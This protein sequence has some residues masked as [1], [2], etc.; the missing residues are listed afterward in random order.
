M[1]SV[2]SISTTGC[3][4][5]AWLFC[6]NYHLLTH[7]LILLIYYVY[8]SLFSVPFHS[9]TPPHLEYQLIRAYISCFV[10]WCSQHLRTMF[11]GT[12]GTNDLCWVKGWMNEW[13]SLWILMLSFI[14]FSLHTF[15]YSVLL[16]LFLCFILYLSSDL[17]LSAHVKEWRNKT[18][19][20]LQPL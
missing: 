17:W 8:S 11:F 20:S 19:W 13:I 18:K 15:L 7:Y 4:S 1:P 2:P 16:F 9:L 3:L 12:W 6:N 10:Y 14:S 5:P